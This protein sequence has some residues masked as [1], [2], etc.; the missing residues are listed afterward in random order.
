MPQFIDDCRWVRKLTPSYKLIH[1]EQ[2]QATPPKNYL[3]GVQN[4]Q[5]TLPFR[6][7]LD[8]Q[9]E[10][11]HRQY[12]AAS[13]PKYTPALEVHLGRL[14]EVGEVLCLSLFSGGNAATE[15]LFYAASQ[16]L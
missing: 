2:W 9:G 14:G 8:R 7:L 13:L 12:K 10:N 5:T 15:Q 11:E 6:G 16:L 1:L 4:P 3:G